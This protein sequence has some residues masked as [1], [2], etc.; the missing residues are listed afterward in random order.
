MKN[1]SLKSKLASAI[2]KI[3]SK[4]AERIKVKGIEAHT[5]VTESAI[6]YVMKF[7]I[8]KNNEYN[9]I[10]FETKWKMHIN[11]SVISLYIYRLKYCAIVIKRAY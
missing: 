5:K 9:Q 11:N 10:L 4:G 8:M 1:P 3:R 2:V 7:Q 6:G